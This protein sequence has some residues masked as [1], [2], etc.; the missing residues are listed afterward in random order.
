MGRVFSLW[1]LRKSF[2]FASSTQKKKFKNV[3][4]RFLKN[5]GDSREIIVSKDFFEKLESYLKADER[6]SDKIMFSQ[7]Q[8]LI[9]FTSDSK[10]LVFK[11]GV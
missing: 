6:F 2:F 3:D 10:K 8:N 1:P 11:V 4:E 7:N 5:M 9:L